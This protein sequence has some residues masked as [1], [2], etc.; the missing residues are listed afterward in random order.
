MI[1]LIINVQLFANKDSQI[2]YNYV[3]DVKQI[4]IITKHVP[5][6]FALRLHSTQH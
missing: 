2:V 5:I 3:C 6:H 1:L 4:S